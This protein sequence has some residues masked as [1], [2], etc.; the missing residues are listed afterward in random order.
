MAD[1]DATK[2]DV[3]EAQSRN[4]G[5]KTFLDLGPLL[6]FF[7]VYFV[8]GKFLPDPK[9]AIFWGTGF[10]IGATALS[11][12]ASR[13]LFGHFPVMPVVTAALVAV[14]GGLTLYLQN[15]MFIK[16]K[17]TIL[18]ALFSLALIIGL[19]LKRFFLKSIFAEVMKLTDPGW[20]ILTI[21]WAVFFA[22]LAVL[23]EFVWRT[24]SESTWVTYKVFGTLPLIMIFAAA[25]VGLLK[26]YEVHG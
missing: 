13:I 5:L 24:F 25:Q 14:F 16:M 8:A 15:D 23:N 21:R 9:Q 17:P 6:V 3:A 12:A 26:K 18:Y 4:H 10:L 7:A 22:A 11:L 20:R 1:H 2:S 19:A